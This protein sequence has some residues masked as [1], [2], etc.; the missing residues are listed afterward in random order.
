MSVAVIADIVGSRGLADRAVA[1]RII[2]Q[3]VLTVEQDFPSAERPLQPTVGDELQGVYPTV[4]AAMSGLLLLRLVL[5]EGIDC[6]YG[7]GIGTLIE[8]PSRVGALA[9]GPGWWAAREAIDIVH[10]RQARSVR[11]SRTWIVAADEADAVGTHVAN[12]YV[13]ARDQV[14][15][16]MSERTRRLTYGR[17]LGRTQGEL[18][19]SEGIT[20]SAVSQALAT[21][22]AGALIEGF[23]QLQIAG[24]AAGES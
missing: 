17:L 7:I 20:Q 24:T 3:S 5:P 6:R 23:A 11:G 10:A 1:Q 9:E 13:L 15:S 22:G 19:R 4:T 14:I 2:D 12:A 18:A 16:E 21:A 8:V